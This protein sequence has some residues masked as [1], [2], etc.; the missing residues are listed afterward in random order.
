MSAIPF[1]IPPQGTCEHILEG[2]KDAVYAL[3]VLDDG[4]VVRRN[5][6]SP[7]RACCDARRRGQRARRVSV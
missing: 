1:Q 5:G 3:C 7:S 2:H 6:R 4:R